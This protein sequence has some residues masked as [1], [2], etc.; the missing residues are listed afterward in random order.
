MTML[1]TLSAADFESLVGQNLSFEFAAGAYELELVE[2][3]PI[4]NPSPREAPP[5][6]LILRG[7]RNSPLQQGVYRVQHPERGPLDLFMVALGPDAH[8]LVYEIIFN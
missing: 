2:V 8:G 5:F 4:R 7:P 3:R 6:A 1:N